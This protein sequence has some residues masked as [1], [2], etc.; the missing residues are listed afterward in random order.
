M[1]HIRGFGG[2]FIYS[3]DAKALV[4]WYT[5]HLGL[6]FDEYSPGKSYGLTFFTRD[7]EDVEVRVGE[8]FSIFQAEEELGHGRREFRM[9]F[10]VRDAAA[11]RAT[12]EGAGIACED[13]QVFEYG[14]FFWATD[15]D[16]N[17]LEFWQPAD[18][19]GF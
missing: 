16:G 11:L 6:A 19:S 15:P 1:G 9:N 13:S 17:R 12:L 14:E 2:V 10:R 5:A 18:I 3:D 4:D 8:V 7:E